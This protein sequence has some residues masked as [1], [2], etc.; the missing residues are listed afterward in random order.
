MNEPEIKNDNPL[1]RLLREGFISEFN[2]EKE[3]VEYCDLRNCDF[4]GVSLRGMD[5]EGVD[6]RGC[7]FRQADLRALDLSGAKLEGASIHA[8][9]I[10]GVFFPKELSAD[11]VLLSLIHGTCMRYS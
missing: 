9:K 1:Y 6:L 3:L 7:Y 2:K 11:E 8:A 10:S 5:A 4:R